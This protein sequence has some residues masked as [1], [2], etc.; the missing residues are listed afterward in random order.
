MIP[1][2]RSG[3]EKHRTCV[4]QFAPLLD[5]IENAVIQPFGRRRTN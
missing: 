3:N 4:G 1:D 2:E 5:K